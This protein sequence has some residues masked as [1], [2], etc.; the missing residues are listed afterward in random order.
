MEQVNSGEMPP[1][2]DKEPKPTQAGPNNGSG[3]TLPQV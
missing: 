1:K 2:K 3:R